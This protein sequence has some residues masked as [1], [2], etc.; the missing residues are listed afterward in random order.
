MTLTVPLDKQAPAPTR[1]TRVCRSTTQSVIALVC[2]RIASSPTGMAPCPV[3]CTVTFRPCA[4]AKRT[5]SATWC[6][7]VANT[8]A[9]GRTGTA[10]FHGVQRS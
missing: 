2:T 8:T 9:A 1:A 3:A 6:A 4:A 7:E 5:A 10:T